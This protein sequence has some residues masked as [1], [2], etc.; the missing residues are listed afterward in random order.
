[1]SMAEAGCGRARSPRVRA[2]GWSVVCILGML[3]AAT[4][5]GQTGVAPRGR[6][7]RSNPYLVS[8]MAHLIWMRSHV[9]SSS[10]KYFR[11]TRNI[12]ARRSAEW[13]DEAGFIPIGTGI[14]PFNGIFDGNGKTIANLYIRRPGRD[15][16]GLFGGVGKY[17][18]VKNLTLTGGMIE[19]HIDVGAVAGIN[20]GRIHNCQSTATVTGRS[21]NVGGLVGNNHLGTV[22]VCRSHA[23]VYGGD[24]VGGVVGINNRH[25]TVKQCQA[26]G[27]AKGGSCIGG[28]VGINYENAKIVQSDGSGTV[29]GRTFAAGGLVGMN[30]YGTVLR[31]RSQADVWGGMHVG[32]LVGDNANYATIRECFAGGPVHGS[33]NV[34]GLVGK[35]LS[36]VRD[37]Y[38]RGGAQGRYHVGGLIGH[39]DGA[40]GGTANRCF[41]T[42]R[43]SGLP[44]GGTVGG[45]IGSNSGDPGETA[46]TSHWDRQTT[47]QANSAGGVRHDTAEMKQ[48]GTYVLWNFNT[49]WRNR[50]N[51][52]YPSL[53]RTP[54]AIL[55]VG[56]AVRNVRA[57]EGTTSFVVTNKGYGHM[58]YQ[59]TPFDRWLEIYRGQSGESGDRI[60]VYFE[61]NPGT[62]ARTGTVAVY[63]P[64]A[65]WSPK[66]V[67]VVQA[68][69]SPARGVGDS[70]KDGP[71]GVSGQETR[72]VAWARAADGG[73]EMAPELVDNDPETVWTGDAG[74]AEWALVADLGRLIRLE[75]V[76]VDFAGPAWEGIEG[77]GA[78]A[79]EEWFGL[80]G[81]LGNPVACRYLYLRLKDEQGGIPPAI[82]EI[83][84]E[85][86]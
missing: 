36:L 57:G 2:R 54:E 41:A 44:E 47:R 78:V 63:A 7:T 83:R 71:E 6:G 16:V 28:L 27:V 14:K 19:G 70:V 79:P 20:E 22:S 45:L 38:A 13:N 58:E 26:D 85:E 68:G 64:F 55:A 51:V 77:M 75:S 65:L 10:G 4:A 66:L 59:A 43:V 46:G 52:T 40:H 15:Y 21:F 23:W 60:R 29:E 32:G 81:A 33:T 24:T 11:V 30:Y 73:W 1:M 5:T 76:E 82:R 72:K 49:I 34:G 3:W 74:L 8:G 25:G 86:E 80:D 18:V 53:R 31:C 67:R 50:E 62:T 12:E 35:N 37:S 69:R 42:G 9:G 17:G 61:A 56:P 48:K 84:W 39:M